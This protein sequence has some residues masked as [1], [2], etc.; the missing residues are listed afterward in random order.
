MATGGTMIQDTLLNSKIN[1]NT[2]KSQTLKQNYWKSDDVHRVAQR[3]PGLYQTRAVPQV[4]FGLS[5]KQF[6]HGGAS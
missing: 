6:G 1:R 5:T 2:E 3:T 4:K